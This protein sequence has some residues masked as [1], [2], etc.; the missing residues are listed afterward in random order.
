MD[1][2]LYKTG[3]STPVVT[4]E[5]VEYYTDNLVETEDGSIYGPFAADF[6]LSSLQDCSETL[7]ATWRA[8][9]VS[10]QEQLRA[11][12]DFLAAIQGVAL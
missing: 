10:P 1:L 8:A 9:H 4:I 2:Y 7:R 11:D 5:N 6:E 3:A 12:V